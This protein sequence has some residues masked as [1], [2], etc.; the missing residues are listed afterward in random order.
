MKELTQYERAIQ[1]MAIT[2]A[3]KRQRL[4]EIKKMKIALAA[5]AR[6]TV[7]KIAPR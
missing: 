6:Q 2:P 5:S 1:A 7:E 4:D 3:E